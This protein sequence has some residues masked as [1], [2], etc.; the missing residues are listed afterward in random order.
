MLSLF[1]TAAC[2]AVKERSFVLIII[3]SHKN[4]TWEIEDS[5]FS[6]KSNKEKG[7]SSCKCLK[8]RKGG[9]EGDDT[10]KN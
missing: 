5:F 6:N 7:D 9:G 2:L 1:F 4:I 8:K 3:T 10:Q